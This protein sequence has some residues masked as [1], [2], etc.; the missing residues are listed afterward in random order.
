MI[1][2][3][4]SRY[5]YLNVAYTRL[6]LATNHGTT[7]MILGALLPL[8]VA[9]PI[10][11]VSHFV[12]DTLPH[13]GIPNKNRNASKMYKRIVYVDT[14]IALSFAVLSAVTG[15]WSMF[16]VGWVAYSPDAYWVYMYAKSKTFNLKPKNR[17]AKFHQRIQHEKPW[18]LFIELPL[19]SMLVFTVFQMM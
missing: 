6:M 1:P 8:P 19:A 3:H 5:F 2:T 11:F 13:Y 9:I 4:E 7:G 12:M 14:S 15:H 18:G 10:A 17:F 16:L